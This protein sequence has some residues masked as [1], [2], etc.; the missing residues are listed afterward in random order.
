MKLTEKAKEDF[1]KWY[2]H[3]DKENS[4]LPSMIEWFYVYP[5]SM[6]YGVIVDWFDSVEIYI[7]V[8]SMDLG[9]EFYWIINDDEMTDGNEDTRPEARTQ[10]IIKANEIYN[11]K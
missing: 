9:K 7:E 3:K 2:N 1:E 5:D 6:Q 4:S 8:L 11:E 10:T